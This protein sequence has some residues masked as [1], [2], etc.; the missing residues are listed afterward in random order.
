MRGLIQVLIFVVSRETCVEVD[1]LACA[2]QLHTDGGF[3]DG[4]ECT[5]YRLFVRDGFATCYC[6]W[7]VLRD[8]PP[9]RF[10]N[11]GD[12]ACLDDIA[13]RQIMGHGSLGK[14]IS[15]FYLLMQCLK[16]GLKEG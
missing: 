4:C 15:L 5:T 1:F 8:E 2:P 13:V 14:A 12:E 16:V 9:H 10:D 7:F 6:P 11:T 3:V